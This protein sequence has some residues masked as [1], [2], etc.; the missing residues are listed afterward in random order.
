MKTVKIAFFDTKSHEK[1]FF[2]KSAAQIE[3]EAAADGADIET[4]EGSVHFEFDFFLDHLNEGTVEMCAGHD[5]A[6]IFANDQITPSIAKKLSE[7]GVK[8]LALRSVGYNNVD[9]KACEEAGLKVVHVDEYSAHTTAEFAIALLQTLNRRIHAAYNR[10][11][12]GDFRTDNF[13]GT[14]IYQKTVGIIGAGK[15]GKAAAEI[16]RGYGA[17]VLLN[18]AHQNPEFGQKTGAEYVNLTEIFKNSDFIMLFCPLV[19]ETRNIINENCISLMKKDA[20][21]VNTGRTALID[22][23]ALLDALNSGRIRGVAFDI[24]EEDRQNLYGDDW[25]AKFIQN[26]DFEQLLK[27]PNALLTYHQAY[28][29]EENLSVVARTTLDNIREIL[30]DDGQCKNLIHAS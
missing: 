18:A 3:D 10:T 7:L 20:V 2:V 25:S 28:L 17:R 23:K 1:A 15:I 11:R 24:Y 29:T 13:V 30:S 19:N 9:L 8:V 4:L 26:E 27:L 12:D 14:E 5:A 21:I 22:S 16:F 6:C